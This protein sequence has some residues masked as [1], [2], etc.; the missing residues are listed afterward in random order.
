MVSKG[1]VWSMDL[2]I[3][4]IIF[5]LAIGIFYFLTND[6]AESDQSKLILE[7]QVVADKVASE[8]GVGILDGTAVDEEKLVRLVQKI[9]K[10][11]HGTKEELGIQHE[12]CLLLLDEEE[13]VMLL[14]NGT[15]HDFVGIG[16]PELTVTLPS[17]NK[18]CDCGERLADCD[19][20]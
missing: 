19:N 17:R 9:Q 16:N 15:E 12:F 1:Q 13:N 10:D 5:L 14:S 6:R 3:G 2:I 8:E 7:S 4:V 18:E 11:Y 20:V